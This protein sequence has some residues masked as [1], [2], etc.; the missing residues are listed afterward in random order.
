MTWVARLE[1]WGKRYAKDRKNGMVVKV[2]RGKMQGQGGKA[3]EC[4]KG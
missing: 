4:G 1:W 3:V 2:T